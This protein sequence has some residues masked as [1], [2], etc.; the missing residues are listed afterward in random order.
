MTVKSII[1]IE[2][3]DDKFRGFAILFQKYQDALAK[4]PAMWQAVNREVELQRKGFE[5]IAAEALVQRE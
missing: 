5:A 2:I 1:D 4:S 3:V